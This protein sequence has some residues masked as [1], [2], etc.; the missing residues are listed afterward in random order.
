VEVSANPSFERIDE[1]FPI[2]PEV[3]PIPPGSYGWTTWMLRGNT[4]ASR[5]VSATFTATLG[6]LWSG[7]Q[8]TVSGS[9]TVRPSFRFTA[10][11]SG[12]HTAAELDV[13]AGSFTKTFW[14]TRANYSFSRNMFIDA[15]LQ[16]DP[17]STLF[18]A[19][20]RYNFIHHPLSDLF[21]VYNEQRF[22]TGELIQPGRS[23]TIKFTQMLAF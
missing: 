7:T 13:P 10:T 3:D 1:E 23:L 19:N 12:Q 9:I 11:L 17:E 21:V 16:Y 5:A 4:D 14:T 18:N 2:D 6:G 8:E 22:S 20:V 15:L